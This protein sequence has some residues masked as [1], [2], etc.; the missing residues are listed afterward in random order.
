MISGNAHPRLCATRALSTMRGPPPTATQLRCWTTTKASTCPALPRLQR[1]RRPP[2]ATGATAPTRPEP[3][4]PRQGARSPRRARR[5]EPHRAPDQRVRRRRRCLAAPRPTTC[6]YTTIKDRD[7]RAAVRLRL[8]VTPVGVP[9]DNCPVCPRRPS[10]AAAPSP[11]SRSVP[12]EA[13]PFVMQVNCPVST[14]RP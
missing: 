7:Y 11:L 1:G 8:G 3:R 6:S 13:A 9:V 10:F 2:T 4:R 5:E 14:K 12:G